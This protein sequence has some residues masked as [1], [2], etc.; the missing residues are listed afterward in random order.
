MIDKETNWDSVEQKLREKNYNELLQEMRKLYELSPGN[1]LFLETRCLGNSGSLQVSKEQIRNALTP[2][3]LGNE[4][5]N[6]EVA[7]RVILHYKLSNED[8]KGVAELMVYYI[9]IASQYTLDKGGDGDDGY[10]ESLEELFEGAVEHL[11]DMYNRNEDI[12]SF[13]RRLGKIVDAAQVIRPDYHE[14]LRRIFS[15]AF[16]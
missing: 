13:A 12:G 7:D 4:D 10:Y 16:R 3:A 9:E 5:M 11:K 14:S 2:D 15:E 1:R 6:W 8:E